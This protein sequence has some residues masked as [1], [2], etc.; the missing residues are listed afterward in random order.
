MRDNL[1]IIGGG[2]AGLFSAVAAASRLGAGRV[3]VLERLDRVGKKL[4]ATG[5]GRCNLT[6]LECTP[7]RYHGKDPAFPLAA[8]RALPP[9]EVLRFFE[10]QGVLTR[11]EGDGKVYPYSNQA[12]S[13]VDALRF[14]CEARGVRTICGEEIQRLS[15]NNSRFLL[16][17]NS[18]YEAGAVIVTAGGRASPH[19]GSNG[20]GYRLLEAFGHKTTF[21]FPAIVQVKTEN[22]LTKQLAGVKWECAAAA[23]VDGAVLRMEMGEVLFTS[24][25]LSGP[26][27]LQLSRTAGE[28]GDRCKICLDLLPAFS[29][30]ELRL[31]LEHRKETLSSRLLMEFLSG[32]LPKRLG[33]VALKS[34]GYD[35][36]RSAASLSQDDCQKM[37][38]HL[39]CVAF[40]VTGVMDF[41]N[42]Q[43]TAGGVSTRGFNP[44]TLMSRRQPGLFAA[45]EVLDVDGD[46]GG[47]NLQWAFSSG[48]RAGL[49]AAEWL[50]EP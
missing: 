49:S 47:F 44:E 14:A 1:V 8:L 29:E 11:I 27:V 46:C 30:R 6:N 48:Y 20:S 16:E 45:G 40:P 15:V 38:Q 17:G 24:Y 41:K 43:V 34:A 21:L 10:A 33:Q 37:A 4:L 42:A 36:K 9:K 3:W 18:R 7:E 2:A 32:F 19:L 28:F 39:K 12:G 25:G 22:T 35:L 26:P 23:V 13:V 50:L 5:N 31:L